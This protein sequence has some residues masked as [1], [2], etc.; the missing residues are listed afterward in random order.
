MRIF[1][2][3]GP[4]HTKGRAPHSFMVKGV[5]KIPIPNK[6]GSQIDGNLIRRVIKLAEISED[7]WQKAGTR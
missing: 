4:R 5:R 7:E 2:F 3:E 6:H 1:G